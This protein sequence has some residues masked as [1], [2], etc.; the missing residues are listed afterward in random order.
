MILWLVLVRKKDISHRDLDMISEVE[1]TLQWEILPR[2]MLGYL[3]LY[4]ILRC[5]K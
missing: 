2:N 4:F 3:R 5:M 1:R